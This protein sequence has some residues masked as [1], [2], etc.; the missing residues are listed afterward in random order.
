MRQTTL[1]RTKRGYV[2][3]L[4]KLPG[5]TPESSGEKKAT[6]QKFYLG[7]DKE[8]AQNRLEAIIT[9]WTEF[10]RKTGRD[11][12][13]HWHLEAA[14]A[15]ARGEPLLVRR[16]DHE[17]EDNLFRRF[18]EWS[19][20]LKVPVIVDPAH[21]G[22]FELGREAQ[23]REVLKSQERLSE[24]LGTPNA[25]GQNLHDAIEAY[26]QHIQRDYLDPTDGTLTDNGKTKIDQ[27][28]TITNYVPNLDL[29]A[30]D[31]HGTDEIFA[32]FRRRPV[33]QRYGK[34]MSR[35]SCS[36]YIGELGRFFHWMHLSKD[37]NWR[38]PEDYDAISRRPR[39][40]DSDVEHEAKEVPTWTI[41]ELKLLNEY[42]LP[43]ERVFLLLG[44]NAAYGADQAGRLR[45]SHL[46]LA[47][48]EGKPSYI[49]RIRR[50]K[51]TRSLHLLWRQ[52][53]QALRWALDR[54][55]KQNHPEDF[56]LLT[57]K[58][59]PYWDKTK[60]GNRK[61]AIPNMW[62][63]LLD[64]VQK[65]HP[66]FRRLPFNSLRDTSAD[67]IRRIAGEEIASLHLAHK[68]QSKDEHLRRYTNPVRKRHYKALRRLETKLQPV[69]SAA[70]LDP[71]TTRQKNYIGLVKVKQ[72]KQ[73]HDN[74]IGASEIAK[75]LKIS[76]TTVYR[77]LP[78]QDGEPAAQA[79][80]GHEET[81][82]NDAPR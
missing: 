60:A 25:V 57:D 2:R 42:A 38:K 73:L 12:W 59:H 54:R 77:Y 20:Q 69:F 45:V 37:W 15:V 80:V 58:L 1:K 40:L 44:L 74:G 82:E 71:F 63:R 36:N 8:A 72:I 10:T 32:I 14:K 23:V 65:D 55:N 16:F 49:K 66:K 70:G 7:H 34:P 30:L 3:N 62:N 61:Q 19:R 26:R 41:D 48:E 17:P 6:Q 4:G 5:Q 29:G 53:E 24:S 68:H 47:D 52:T 56:L 35:K 46:H 79:T 18:N 75:T 67:S 31:Y 27:L 33:S 43:I 51:K 28:K 64:R 9:L 21:Q 76:T 81:G 50:K 78:K 13:D 39:E 22:L 11:S